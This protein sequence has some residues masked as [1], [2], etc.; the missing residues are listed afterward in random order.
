[1][2]LMRMQDDVPRYAALLHNA[3]IFCRDVAA[4]ELE[5]LERITG[6]KLVPHQPTPSDL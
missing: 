4:D 6:T 2:L 5:G 3:A 1:M